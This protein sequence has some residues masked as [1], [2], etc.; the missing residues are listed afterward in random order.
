MLDIRG[1]LVAQCG[2]RRAMVRGLGDRIGIDL[3][4]VRDALALSRSLP[5]G[6]RDA[7]AGAMLA[8]AARGGVRV[9]YRIGGKVRG[10][11]VPGRSGGLLARVCTRALGVPM[12]SVWIRGQ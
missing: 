7:G 12:T 5:T 6:R 11:W 1:E 10:E 9:E 4:G 3:G 2:Q 8:I